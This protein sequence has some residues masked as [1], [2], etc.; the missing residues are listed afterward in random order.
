MS[1]LANRFRAANDEIDRYFATTDPA[2]AVHEK[3]EQAFVHTAAL[4]RALGPVLDQAR[5]ETDDPMLRSELARYMANLERLHR[6]CDGEMRVLSARRKRLW[7][8]EQAWRARQ[9][10]HCER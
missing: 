2:D 3:R 5:S 4:I 8:E 10:W 7:F 9:Q 6:H 1:N